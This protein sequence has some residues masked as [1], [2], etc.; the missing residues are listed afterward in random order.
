MGRGLRA[1][2][3]LGASAPPLRVRCKGGASGLNYTEGRGLSRGGVCLQ[4]L[5][6]GRGGTNTRKRRG[7]A[8]G[9]FLSVRT[10]GPPLALPRPAA[11]TRTFHPPLP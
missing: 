3:C 9:V 10:L 4:E 1:A 6:L 8:Y 2:Y 7:E 5:G 11:V